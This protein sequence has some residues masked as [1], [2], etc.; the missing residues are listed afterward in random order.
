MNSG[1]KTIYQK[2]FCWQFIV[3]DESINNKY[4]DKFINKKKKLCDHY[5]YK[6]VKRTKLKVNLA[7]LFV[8]LKFMTTSFT[9]LCFACLFWAYYRM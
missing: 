1:T 5:N 8:S 4:I 2:N 3:D 6:I 9:C 7:T